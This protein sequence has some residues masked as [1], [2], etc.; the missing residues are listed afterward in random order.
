MHR[1]SRPHSSSNDI[2]ILFI[3]P[4]PE[5]TPVSVGCRHIFVVRVPPQVPVIADLPRRLTLM[6]QEGTPSLDYQKDVNFIYPI[7]DNEKY[8][9]SRSAVASQQNK[10]PVA[11][12]RRQNLQLHSARS[13]TTRPSATGKSGGRSTSAATKLIRP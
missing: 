7:V 10:P 1:E 6:R 5:A 9:L 11:P 12:R 4:P 3:R 13:N 2:D 8:T